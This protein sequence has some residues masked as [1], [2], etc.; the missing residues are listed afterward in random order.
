MDDLPL[1]AF[2]AEG[3]E[4][5]IRRHNALYWDKGAPEISDE[6]YDLLVRRLRQMRPDSPV[7]SELG[8]ER[9]GDEG[10][11]PSANEDALRALPSGSK[12][13]HLAP[14]LS[15]DKCYAEDE[16]HRWF[17]RFEGHAL[18]SPKVD[19]VAMSVRYDAD[20]RLLVA[21]T[22]GS[23]L[24][25]DAITQNVRFVA[26]VPERIA[27]GPLEV[28]GET[29]MPL[30]VFRARF[31][32]DF[33]N[34]RNLAAGG[35][36]Q[37]EASHTGDYGL[38][39]FA[40]D[41]LGLDLPTEE[42]KRERLKALGFEPVPAAHATRETGQGVFDAF[43]RDRDALDYET[44]GVVFKVADVAQHDTMGATA[45]HPRYAIAYKYQGE[46]GFTELEGLLW[47]VSRTG[48][49]N[50]VACL[51]PISL[52][53]VTVTRASLHNLGI[54]EALAGLEP[55]ALAVGDNPGALSPGARVLVTRR[56]GVIPHVES[57][58]EAGA[59]L[60]NIPAVCPSC[61][62][63]T[64]RE[65]DLLVAEHLPTCATQAV[66]KLVHFVAVTDMDG[67]GPKLLEQLFDAEHVV[68]PADL[69][70]LTLADLLPLERMARKSAE[71][72]LSAIAAKRTLEL[73]TFLAALGIEDLGP[74]M[75]R[76]L[77]SAHPSLAA[78]RAADAE[79]L[80]AIDGFGEIVADKVVEGLASWS[81]GIDALLEHVEVTAPPEPSEAD[82]ALPLHGY[83]IVFTG[84]MTSMG[85]SDAQKRARAAGATTPSGVSKAVTHVVLGDGDYPRY[86]AGWRSTKLKKAE[87]WIEG[88]ASLQIVSESTFRS[89]I[90]EDSD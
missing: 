58:A 44:D 11:I 7:L 34:P 78:I 65:G 3:L 5:E 82:A 86:E 38:R 31:A 80:T 19:G 66:R 74:N 48:S 51:A 16:L 69:Y 36:K 75:A 45:H 41:G 15:L 27:E 47:S 2:D 28:R 70:A 53:G 90:G 14:M 35:L 87:Q 52:S 12:V 56:G 84:K 10:A 89:W 21:A 26:G 50:P 46:S 79:T 6:A 76:K 57:I 22:R 40:Y 55:G 17:D 24:V 61:G 71:N 68:S 54:M 20:G 4:A 83:A 1:F 72:V 43:E 42:A 33:A 18:A 49:I 37:K 30:S 62:A 81:E 29:Y 77:A 60:L 23:G 8:E 64:R 32:S 73:S 67:V 39:F 59:G 9:Q 88:G 13:E 25:G 85:R 63:P